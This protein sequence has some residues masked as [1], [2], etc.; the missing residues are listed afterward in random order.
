MAKAAVHQ[1]A[2]RFDDCTVPVRDVRF[3]LLSVRLKTIGSLLP[4]IVNPLDADAA[5]AKVASVRRK[6]KEAL[7]EAL[8]R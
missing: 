6:L 4:V 5:E 3:L 8:L 7:S 1:Q 2:H